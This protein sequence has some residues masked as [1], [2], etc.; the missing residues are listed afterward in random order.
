M[1]TV[2]K[3][4]LALA[5]AGV[6]A[7]ASAA[8]FKVGETQKKHGMEVQ[9]L[10]IQAVTLS[11]EPVPAE[12]EGHDHSKHDQDGE[13]SDHGKSEG[14]H[15]GHAGHGGPADIHLEASIHAAKD[16]A[17]GFPKGAWV[18][19]LNVTYHIAKNGAFFEKRGRL[20]PM[21]ANAGPHYGANLKLDGPGKYYVTYKISP[22]RGSQFPYHTDKETGV[23]EWWPTFELKDQFTYLGAGKKGGY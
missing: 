11:K 13:H 19:Y 4:L 6:T 10:Y 16:N 8:E 3:S 12:E 14:G 21:A 7:S 20:M 15:G 2:K 18:P 22:P 9:M 23:Q 1:T 17:W 5:L